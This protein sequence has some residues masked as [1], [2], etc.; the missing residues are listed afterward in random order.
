[1]GSSSDLAENAKTVI[2]S[3]EKIKYPNDKIKN[4]YKKILQNKRWKICLNY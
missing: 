1:M 3:F 2:A 4:R